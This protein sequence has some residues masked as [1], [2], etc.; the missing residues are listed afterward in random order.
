M[1]QTHVWFLKRAQIVVADV[2]A[3]FDGQGL[4]RFDD[5]DSITMFADYRVPQ[6]LV[7]FGCLRY[8]DELTEA[9]RQGVRLQPGERREMEIRAGSIWAVER[10]VQELRRSIGVAQQQQQPQGRAG[11]AH[12]VNA[13]LVDFWLW[14]T[15]KRERDAMAHVPIHK[16]RGIMY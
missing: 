1:Q 7:H 9:L 5:I 14:D 15:A 4:G 10:V 6:A 8:S 13:I 2:W 3:C 12:R 11:P 16:T